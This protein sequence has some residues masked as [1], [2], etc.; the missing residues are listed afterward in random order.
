MKRKKADIASFFRASG[1]KLAKAKNEDEMEKKQAESEDEEP[2]ESSNLNGPPDVS[3]RLI[4]SRTEE[5]S[6][7][8]GP[9]GSPDS[10]R[11][12]SDSERE[13]PPTTSGGPSG[14]PVVTS[15][16]YRLSCEKRVVGLMKARTLGNSATRLRAALVEQHNKEWLGLTLRYLSVLEQLQ[17]SALQLVTVPP[18]KPIAN[19]PWMISVY[20]REAFG[21]LEEKKARFTWKA[22]TNVTW[23][24]SHF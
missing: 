5:S 21:R 16:L 2:P 4:E 7:R 14:P 10:H 20:A 19:V 3:E 6:L 23:S 17:V 9:S 24:G 1:K 18:M 8:S 15:C 22:H 12:D 11:E 13:E